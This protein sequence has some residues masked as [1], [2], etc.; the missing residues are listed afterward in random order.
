MRGNLAAHA[1]SLSAARRR[2]LYTRAFATGS[3]S[4][5]GTTCSIAQ[6]SPG[7]IVAAIAEV[8]EVRGCAAIV[9]RGRCS[10]T[11]PDG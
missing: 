3:R 6:S 11:Y 10:D 7:V 4:R 9:A 8:E 5:E 1:A 2:A